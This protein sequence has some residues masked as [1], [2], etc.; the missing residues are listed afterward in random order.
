[1]L[2]H[3]SL[4]FLMVSTFH[5][6]PSC[7]KL[8]QGLSHS[9]RPNPG[10]R[11]SASPFPVSPQVGSVW[12]LLVVYEVDPHKTDRY[13]T[14]A[15]LFVWSSQEEVVSASSVFLKSCLDLSFMSIL[16]TSCFPHVSLHYIKNI[17]MFFKNLSFFLACFLH[18][19]WVLVLFI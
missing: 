1:M 17:T 18:H 9:G 12:Y 8:S 7:F 2:H 13:S 11:P 4:S 14:S 3:S 15:T 10:R 19:Y 16:Q 5:L 6:I